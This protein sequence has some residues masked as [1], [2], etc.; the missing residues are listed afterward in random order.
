MG[1]QKKI[2]SFG[3]MICGSRG[4]CHVTVSECWYHTEDHYCNLRPL[5][6]F[7]ADGS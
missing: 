5:L 1:L 3:D 4:V 2:L 6:H 7:T